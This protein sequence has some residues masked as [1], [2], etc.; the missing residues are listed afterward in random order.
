EYSE[1]I[2]LDDLE[3]WRF[4]FVTRTEVVDKP[5]KGQTKETKRYRL[6]LPVSVAAR[7]L[8]QLN[9]CI[10]RLGFTAEEKEL[11]EKDG[12]RVVPDHIKKQAPAFQNGGEST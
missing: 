9:R 1:T 6:Y 8:S 3:D 7:C 12:P 10:H 4:K 2:S 11:P 5:R